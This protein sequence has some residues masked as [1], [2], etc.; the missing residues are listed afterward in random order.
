MNSTEILKNLRNPALLTE[1]TLP[2]LKQ[3]VHDFPWFQTGWVLYLKNLKNLNHADYPSVLQQSALRV[4][5]RIWL[6]KFIEDSNQE[7][8]LNNVFQDNHFNIEEYPAGETE[9][10]QT[11]SSGK[12]KLIESFLAKGA[13]FKHLSPAEPGIPA[14]D[15]AEKA[16]SESDD[17]VTETFANLLF[18]QAKYNKAIK[19]FEKLSLKFPEKSI[20][21]AARIE[22]VKILMNVNKE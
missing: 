14:I 8:S 19:A 16:V 22:E 2:S 3:Y 9:N 12:L 7:E 15:L 13:T 18:N 10:G 6:K 21:F 17:I 5:N 1:T 11:T 20:Y 4:S